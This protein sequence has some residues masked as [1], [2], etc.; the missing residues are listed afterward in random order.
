MRRFIQ[1]GKRISSFTRTF[2]RMRWALN[3]DGVGVRGVLASRAI[4]PDGDIDIEFSTGPNAVGNIGTEYCVIS[5][6]LSNNFSAKEFRLYFNTSTNALQAQVGGTYQASSA[7]VTLKPN[8]DYRFLLRGALIEV[9]VNGELTSSTPFTRGVSREA[10]AVTV[11]GAET[12]GSATTFR[13][14]FKG[15]L[16]NVRVNGIRW[17]MADRNQAIQLPEPSGLGAELLV[18]PS[19]AS[20]GSGWGK[21]SITVRS[22]SSNHFRLTNTRASYAGAI[23]QTIPTTIGNKYVIRFKVGFQTG[24]TNFRVSINSTAA[25]QYTGD[26]LAAN[27]TVSDQYLFVVFIATT[28]SATV[29]LL[30]NSS[31]EGSYVDVL[32][33][34]VKPLGTCNPMTISNATSAN[35][36]QVVDDYVRKFRSLLNFD[37]VGIRGALANRVINP[38]GDNTF[39]FWSPETSGVII[40]QNIVATVNLREFTLYGDALGLYMNIGGV[41][42]V[43]CTAAQGF[44]LGKK[45]WLTLVGSNFTL[46]KNTESN[47]IRSASFTKGAAREPTAQTIIGARANGTASAFS[48]YFKGIQRDIKINGTLW[49]IADRNQSIQLPDPSGLGAELLNT[50][51]FLEPNGYVNT[52]VTTGINSFKVLAPASGATR[53]AK[54]F[55]LPSVSETT[56]L[57]FDFISKDPDAL[58]SVFVRDGSVV[59]GG[60]V[61]FSGNISALG[62]HRFLVTNSSMVEKNILF[63]VNVPCTFEVRNISIKPLGACNPLT[64]ANVTSAN[65]EDLE[66]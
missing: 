39:E 45:Y 49:P 42:N 14:P 56:I 4:N 31:G 7:A 47:I 32:D 12:H 33:L 54:A 35:W 19:V 53:A 43:I 20:D 30:C 52:I 15:E 60:A 5:Q 57:E 63:A 28:T 65:W 40:A 17:P 3:F 36:M 38:D 61:T 62:K 26:L 9:F 24:G 10:A 55:V 34:T 21:D 22:L 50:S 51:P 18:N 44:E 16:Y 58:L 6:C 29:R 37:G 48:T 46:A 64:L 23:F 13:A 11:V 1:P 27:Y 59:G 25:V 66:I 8:T 41:D 2:A